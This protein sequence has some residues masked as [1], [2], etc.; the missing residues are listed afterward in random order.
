MI[1]KTPSKADLRREIDKQMDDFLNQGKNV[2]EIPRGVS[3]R[4]GAEKPLKADPWQMDKSKADWTYIPEVVDSLE[5]RRHSKAVKPRTK[6]KAKRPKKVLIYDDFGE[7]LRWVWV[8][9]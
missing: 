7:P 2:N 3:S 5:K 4:D 6:N 9:E 1:K 8:D